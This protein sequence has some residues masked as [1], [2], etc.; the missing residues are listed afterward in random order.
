MKLLDSL[1]EKFRKK[2]KVPEELFLTLIV[3][4]DHVA[5]ACWHMRDAKSANLTHAVSRKITTDSWEERTKATDEIITALEERSGTTDIHK[6]IFG[7]PAQYLTVKGD[8]DKSIRSEL[9]TFTQELDLT[10][11]GFV[12]VHQA[13]MYKVKKEDGVPPTAIVIGIYRKEIVIALYKIGVCAGLQIIPNTPERIAAIEMVLK[14]FVDVEVLPSRI[15]LHGADPTILDDFRIEMINHPWS[16]RANFLH[17]PKIVIL[18]PDSVVSGVSQAGSNEITVPT[19]GSTEEKLPQSGIRQNQPHVTS[20]FIHEEK[21]EEEADDTPLGKETDEEEKTGV[22]E[23]SADEDEPLDENGKEETDDVSNEAKEESN[24]RVVTP[25]EIG[26]HTNEDI[27][28]MGKPQIQ[29]KG[30]AQNFK[31]EIEFDDADSDILPKKPGISKPDLHIISSAGGVISSVFLSIVGKMRS[32]KFKFLPLA[33]GGFLVV[34]I[35]LWLSLVV[36]PRTEITLTV[37]P[38][39]IES[40]SSA[41]IDSTAKAVDEKTLTIQGEKLEKTVSGEK[42]ITVTG[43]KNVGDPA[44]GSV[45]IYNKTLSP[46]TFKKGTVVATNNLQFTLD[47]DVQIASATE[48]IGSITFGKGTIAVTAAAIGT[49]SNISAN[50]EFTFKDISDSIAIARNEQAFSGGTSKEVTV[51]SRTD[52]DNLITQITPEL[53]TKAKEELASGVGGTKKLIEETIKTTVAEKTFTEELNQETSQ[54]HGK[55]SMNV[56]GIA[57]DEQILKDVLFEKAKTTVP[58]GYELLRDETTVTIGK[59]TVRKNGTIAV[60]VSLNGK[61]KPFLNATEL[62]KMIAGKRVSDS[63]QTLRGLTGVSDV[64]IRFSYALF[65][66]AIPKESNITIVIKE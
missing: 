60:T 44:K 51:V 11:I 47:D 50:S 56:S 4:S 19:Q 48:S 7:L 2:D 32:M 45:S 20:G 17:F 25:E 30:T 59:M 57:Y 26:F 5:G 22:E 62:K 14:G 13:L 64:D 33:I 37:T 34:G 58:T 15:L 23:K 9:K 40:S 28:E 39:Q 18:P 16:T 63:M 24:V 41:V 38:R 43:K 8:I 42:V 53:I 55:V 1:T 21:E 66:Q 31:R 65:Q 54:L 49:Q 36:F 27:I 12:P 3:D 61:A 6:V 52:Q 29:P 46:R 10:A 35:L